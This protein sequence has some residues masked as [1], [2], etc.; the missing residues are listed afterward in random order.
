MRL[1]LSSFPIGERKRFTM[2]DT[3]IVSTDNGTDTIVANANGDYRH[4]ANAKALAFA[5]SVIGFEAKAAVTA[6]EFG[7]LVFNAVY[8]DGNNLDT[9]IGE[10]KLAAGWATLA[11]SEAGRKAK[12]RL[13]VAFS[14][15]RLV[16]E[17]WQSLSDEQ[18]DSV[19]NG[20]VSV[21]YLASEMRKADATA[22]REAAKAAAEAE[23]AASVTAIGD[24]TA[25]SLADMAS[26]LLAAYQAASVED[27]D[28]A[29]EAIAALFDVVNGDTDVVS[30]EVETAPEAI[31]A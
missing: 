8:V 20:S 2:T 18:R 6:K 22:K 4:Q 10:N 28:A 12:Q 25:K 29:Y 5:T 3:K 7:S 21:L 1:A 19:L 17:R 26:D 24:A 9:I 14:G 15:F 13:E 31:A 30:A 27:R 16:A 11:T 23:A